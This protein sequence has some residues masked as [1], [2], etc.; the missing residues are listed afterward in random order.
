MVFVTALNA[1]RPIQLYIFMSTNPKMTKAWFG[2]VRLMILLFMHARR[3][4]NLITPFQCDLCWFRN[5]QK[6]APN[7]KSQ[8]DSLL[9]AY[10]RRVNL[11][12][13]WSRSPKTVSGSLTGLKKNLSH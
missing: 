12:A 2:S 1:T 4:D 10:I 8:S 3:G 13:F 6:R 9:L 5:L 11:D 7:P